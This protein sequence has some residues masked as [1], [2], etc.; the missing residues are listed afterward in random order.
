MPTILASASRSRANTTVVAIILA[1]I[2]CKE[3]NVPGEQNISIRGFEW[4]IFRDIE[5]IKT[6]LL[7]PSFFLVWLHIRIGISFFK[8]NF[9]PSS[10]GY[11][12]S[13]HRFPFIPHFLFY[14][15]III[16]FGK[17]ITTN[18]IE[19]F[20]VIIDLILDCVVS[21]RPFGATIHNNSGLTTN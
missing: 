21:L 2:C 17:S 15:K 16:D 8:P 5:A 7:N 18:V 9:P 14:F 20:D 10:G 19:E 6:L 1:S 13:C 4:W 11:V 12:V 3:V